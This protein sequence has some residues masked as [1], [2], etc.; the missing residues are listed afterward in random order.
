MNTYTVAALVVLALVATGS[1][2][3][4][5]KKNRW[6]VSVLSKELEGTLK[7]ITSNYVNI[8]G[9]IGYNFTYSLGDP[10]TNAKGTVTMSPRH[11]LLYLPF[12]LLIG[13]RDRFFV[14]IFTKKQI[15]GEGHL[16]QASYLK[17]ANITGI[18]EMKRREAQKDG[19][20][21]ILLWRGADLSAELDK[22]LESLPQ[23]AELRHFCA[24]PETKTFFIHDLPKK[25]KIQGNLE[26]ILLRLPIFMGKEKS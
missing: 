8:G 19:K 14:N 2:F 24:Y 3:Y 1:Y 6:I 7:P 25:G 13:I 5:T 12:S 21:F 18:E 20:R 17:K 9:N 23:A 10:Y 4:G 11:S 15:R 26:A 16:V 22:I